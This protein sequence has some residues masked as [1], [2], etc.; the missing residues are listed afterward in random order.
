MLEFIC[1]LHVLIRRR[2]SVTR[3]IGRSQSDTYERLSP[4][5]TDCTTI[6]TSDT[7]MSRQSP[8]PPLRQRVSPVRTCT[9]GVEDHAGGGYINS[10]STV[11]GS[12]SSGQIGCFPTRPPLHIARQRDQARAR[13][14][15]SP[16]SP[17]ASPTR[18]RD[19]RD[20]L[21]RVRLQIARRL[22][23]SPVMAL[24]PSSRRRPG[25]GGPRWNSG[26]MRPYSRWW[27]R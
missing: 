8:D 19:R 27:C 20:R 21:E 12:L 18:E 14:S 13:A 3:S 10:V 9:S 22:G 4:A 24:Q 5:A 15:T 16:T 6:C 17:S 25:Q 7:C 11:H 1:K 2:A 23:A 26:Y